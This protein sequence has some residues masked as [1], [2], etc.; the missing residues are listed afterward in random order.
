[1]K[2]IDIKH[3]LLTLGLL[4]GAIQGAFAA[5]R[6]Y[7]DA[8]NIEPGETRTLAFY[9]ENEKPYFGFQADL[10]LP[11][12]LEVVAENGKPSITLSSRA[13]N[14]FQIVSNTLADGTLRFGTFSASHES[15]AGDSGALL[16]I[17]VKA[18]S[19]FA[20]GE[21]TVKDILFVGAGD[22]DIEF[23]DISM[24]LGTRHNDTAYIPD[25]RIAV[26]EA[27]QISLLLSN[28]TS[29]TAF[30]VDIVLPVGL[31]IRDG[32]FK[33]G[34]RAAD[35]T[36]SA[37]SFSDGRTRI[38]CL[39]LSNTPFSGNSGALVEFTVV[40]DKDIAEKTEMQLKNVIFTKPDAREYAL[41][42]SVVNITTER[43]QV[44]S[45]TLSPSELIMTADG[46]IS[47]IQATVLPAFAST[48]DL[49]WTTDAPDIASVSQAGALTAI[50]PGTAVITAAATDGSGVTATCT[51]T[52][53]G[54]PV[55]SVVLN[56]ATAS[57]KIDETVSLS[58]TVLPANAWDKSI[59]WS[60][61]DE[62]IATV[63]ENGT[64]TAVALG[65]ATIKATA[66]SNP[67][68]FGECTVSVV[69]TPVTDITLSHSAV[70]LKVG[71][72]VKIEA[73][74]SP[75]AATN[76]AIVWESRN[77]EIASVDEDGLVSALAL[78]STNLTAT[79][80]DGSGA[81]ATC[82]VNVILTPAES[83]T[84]NTPDRT[85]FKVGE[86]IQLSATVLPENAS[87]KTV[88]WYSDNTSVA[89]VDENGS[90]TA[91]SVGTAVIS[92]KS[93]TKEAVISLT[94]IPTPAEAISLDRVTASLNVNRTI[95]LSV[96]FTP[97]TT[98][99]KSVTWTSSDDAV[100]TVDSDGVVTAKALGECVITATTSDGSNKTASCTITV[101]ATPASGI[102]IE[103][104]G[105][106]TLNVGET[107]R[108]HA[109]VLPEDA[110]DKSV[111]WLSESSAVK[112]DS[113]GLA[114]AMAPVENNR[115]LATNSYGQRDVVYVTVVGDSVLWSQ[116]FENKPSDR[117][118]LTA[119]LENASD[120]SYR[121]VRPN[122][123]FV[124][125]EIENIN[126][127]WYATFP[128]EGAYIL[129]AYVTEFPSIKSRKVFNVV[130]PD[131]LMY[132]DGIYYR[133]A[134]SN[135]NTLKVVRGYKMYSGDYTIPSSVNGMKVMAVDDKAF[136]SC[137][138]LGEVVISEGIK[139]IGEQSFGNG[140]LS[141]IVIPASV[142]RI[143]L[144]A[145]NALYKTDGHYS[146]MSISLCGKTPVSVDPLIF[147]G[148]INYDLCELHVPEG[149]SSL[150]ASAE[151]WKEFTKII[152]DL[153][154]PIDVASVEILQGDEASV[155]I[156]QTLQLTAKV[157]PDNATDKTIEWTSEDSRVA[158][159]TAD[160]G[161]I[162]GV[163][164]GQTKVY[165]ISTNGLQDVI[166]VNV[167]PI[168]AENIEIILPATELT[169]GESL[170]AQARISPE[171]TTDKSV[172]WAVSE[173]S[174]ISVDRSGIV[175]AHSPGKAYLFAETA[176]GLS[177]SV[178]LTVK[179]IL[180]RSITIPSDIIVES[181]T[182]Y[183]FT[184]EVFPDNASEK[185]L[186]WES[187]NPDLGSFFGNVFHAYARGEVTATCRAADGSDVSAQCHIKIETHA[188][189]LTLNEHDLNLE[190]DDTFRLVATIEPIDAVDSGPVIW[191]STNTAAV[192]V[193]MNGLITALAEGESVVTAQTQYYPWATDECNIKVSRHSGI[194][195]I[196]IDDAVVHVDGKTITVDGLTSGVTVSLTAL[197]GRVTSFIYDGHPLQ[198]R[199][200][201]SG[202]YIL[203]L[204][205]H[206]LKIAV[207]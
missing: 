50:A 197:D 2:I 186:V 38:A 175:M 24:S 22:K 114:T 33:P 41:P 17:K 55:T 122:G 57:L 20:G 25:F 172:E 151:V 43:A 49:K 183:E 132:I 64:V 144:F 198:I 9:L 120:I 176:N 73:A 45:I 63:D 46:S 47:V 150:Y 131:D 85:S 40:A 5:D 71:E 93:G 12:G 201:H 170:T 67:E 181:G 74:V 121:C 162:H 109:T 34:P 193:D 31:T 146:L 69:P 123:G 58:A 76:K 77:P 134:D 178:L 168:E 192:T 119:G 129:E 30:Q 100:A 86:V 111:T 28:E 23:P 165:A 54:V 91:Q 68:A 128:E 99:D 14:S 190:T 127:K 179:P 141:A 88:T 96:S 171:N 82:A 42:N 19:E 80:A 161:L 199:A 115:I 72:T 105:S 118:E 180:I 89:T 104:S 166:T 147:N 149:T 189:S 78:G 207:F 97:S 26:G 48:K 205:K 191:E 61:S 126:G 10:N 167:L 44:E 56:R 60:S 16:Y 79:A 169:V 94:V 92:A 15:F 184:P 110:T 188:R 90:V 156:G 106:L 135:K 95:Q 27:K 7:M 152:D 173:P 153:P 102:I 203:S 158:T 18:T 155:I 70:A 154:A 81:T 182:Q 194:E 160:S 29:F 13:D 36:V 108:F 206:S 137:T 133:Y 32:S 174:V 195:T 113:D 75:A 185:S 140:T 148:Y 6:F 39:S 177:C 138:E 204:G 200:A 202:T 62:T 107:I 187:S 157:S 143:S 130:N 124:E 35:H 11:E 53:H 83:I 136:Y 66:C 163:N 139:T 159:V 84:I 112:I 125:A 142:N 4:F 145:F 8:V 164:V 21:L 52:V 116:Q 1:M 117:V 59:S 51:V 101:E 87:N 196:S 98:T 37:K 103:P 3:L 65:S